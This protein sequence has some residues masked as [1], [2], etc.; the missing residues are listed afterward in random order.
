M[1]DIKASTNNT[2]LTNATLAINYPQDTLLLGTMEITQ[3]GKDIT[4]GTTIDTNTKNTIIITGINA[5]DIQNYPVKVKFNQTKALIELDETAYSGEV[6]TT[7]IPKVSTQY[8]VEIK[9]G[10]LKLLWVP[11]VLAFK[12]HDLGEVIEGNKNEF[13][14]T[15]IPAYAVASNTRS[16]N[17][18]NSW[19][20]SVATSN[21]NK[22]NSDKK[23]T[24][25]SY[26]LGGNELHE[27]TSNDNSIPPNKEN[28]TS[29]PAS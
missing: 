11:D 21:M 27:Y 24:D 12:G 17:I 4:S 22:A 28:I 8:T 20:V 15:N 14:S 25:L 5:K 6:S 23:I 29:P 26:L 2:D 9:K 3:N 18:T 1:A 19:R 16:K 7:D 10:D 13:E